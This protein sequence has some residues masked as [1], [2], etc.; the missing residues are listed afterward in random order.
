VDRVF[1]SHSWTDNEPCGRLADALRTRGID[2]WFDRDDIEAFDAISA[3]ALEG[4]S[5]SKALVAWYSRSYPTRP[6][7]REEMTLALLAAENAGGEPMRVLAVNP[8]EDLKHVAEARLLDHR[9]AMRDLASDIDALAAAIARRVGQIDGVFGEIPAPAAVPWVGGRGWQGRTGRMVGRLAELW[10]VHDFLSRTSAIGGDGEPGRGVVVVS[11]MGGIGKSLL[12]AE[13]AHLFSSAY[14]GG[15]YWI[16]A[17]GNDIEEGTPVGRGPSSASALAGIALSLGIRLDDPELGGRAVPADGDESWTHAAAVRHAIA[18]HLDEKG[19]PV[20]WVIDDLPS[21][22]TQLEIDEWRCPAASVRTLIT[23]RD[24]VEMSLPT[25]MLGA[26]SAEES[27]QILVDDNSASEDQKRSLAGVNDWLGG[28]PLALAVV[29]AYLRRTHLS[30]DEFLVV[31]RREVAGLDAVVA[32]VFRERLPLPGDHSSRVVAT[33]AVS[34]RGLSARCWDLLRVA[35]PLAEPPIPRWLIGKVFAN[36]AG[37]PV[38]TSTVAAAIGAANRDGL[39]SYGSDGLV[40]HGVVRQVAK[41]IDTDRPRQDLVAQCIYRSL[42]M[43][44]DEVSLDP[45]RNPAETSILQAHARAL[46]VGHPESD[47]IGERSLSESVGRIDFQRGAYGQCYQMWRDAFEGRKSR[48][49]PD[50]PVTLKGQHNF[51]FATEHI[52]D[53]DL[54]EQID[55]ETLEARMRVLGPRN[56]DTVWSQMAIAGHLKRKGDL[57]AAVDLYTEALAVL[58]TLPVTPDSERQLPVLKNNLADTLADLHLY[59][60]A[61]K[62]QQEVFKVRQKL[63]VTHPDR[64][65]TERNIGRIYREK[66][67][68][69]KALAIFQSVLDRRREVLEEGHYQIRISM[70][71]VEMCNEAIAQRLATNAT[72]K[73]TRGSERR[74]GKKKSKK[75]KR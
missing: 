23:T 45:Y 29:G 49:G 34:L 50:H 42:T 47:V 24:D 56:D 37:R 64:L 28:Y 51:A 53:A 52:G 44:L 26:V 66:G 67:E 10:K 9:F 40:V 22:S 5:S 32:A 65:I 43:P 70:R 63:R 59:P 16:S 14:S 6:A 54:A 13:Y 68:L 36:L 62:L 38:S 57:P 21:G 11:G 3:T 71:D 30:G 19:K 15:V 18:S 58:E 1:I 8:E 39:W 35:M 55:R 60:Q 48:L 73:A 27:L 33:L 2:A 12:A 20:L 41:Y 75:R 25:V 7:C 46:A 4:L 31:A 61:M 17:L 69:K 72:A 74:S